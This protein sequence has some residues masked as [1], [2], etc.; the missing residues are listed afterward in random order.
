MLWSSLLLGLAATAV[1][2]P[3]KPSQKPGP[4]A[5]P[6]GPPGYPALPPPKPGNHSLPSNFKW[7][8]TGILVTPKDD[9]RKLAGVKDPSIIH[10]KGTYHVFASSAKAEGYNLLYFNF[11]DVAK[12]NQSPFYYLDQSGIGTGYRAAPQVFYFAPQKLWYLIYQNDNAAYS[13][14]PDISNPAG[15]TAPKVFY[16]NGT[17]AL[18]AE[19]L[20]T[21]Q[22]G[23]WV[24]MWV[25]CDK[26]NCHLFSS[27]DNG[28]LYRSQTT[29]EQ[30]PN[31]MSD[32]VIALSKPRKE[33]LFEAST[34]Y[35]L[36][37]DIYLL[38]V[39]CIGQ[40]QSGGGVRYFKSWTSKDIA[41]PWDEL[42]ST[43]EN[44]F[45]GAANVKFPPGQNW[46]ISISHG[47]MIRNEVDQRLRLG[48]C[49]TWRFLYQGIN[50]A[51]TNVSY[52]ALP[53][54]LGLLTQDGC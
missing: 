45:M 34:I 17:P 21:P 50:P 42:Q 38:L 25:I 8:S 37:K 6:P 43:Q 48:P 27:D 49:G 5:P 35:L 29:L 39:E 13:T 20:V 1:A 46:T 36:E 4:P 3:P 22:Q 54:D 11:T 24:D 32:P 23:Y 31:G 52:N 14:N 18:I 7:S 16:P 2:A 33:D 9:D 12:A 10:H 53:W 47:E 26:K 44:P 41:G 51:P 28:R 40:G 30:F 19:G 15:W